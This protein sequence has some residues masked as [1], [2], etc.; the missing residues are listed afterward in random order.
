MEKKDIAVEQLK[1][2]ARH[3]NNRE[4]VCAITLASA[5]EEILG[6]IAKTRTGTNQLENELSYL[7]G[8][9]DYFSGTTP[10]SRELIAKINS[11]KNNLKHNDG[12]ENIWVEADFEFAAAELFIKAMRNYFDCYSE[13]LNDRT[14]RYLFEHLT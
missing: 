9:Y 3:Y 7:R 13:L 10:P 12:G 2:S 14:S 5:A 4:Y 11:V 8:I 6:Q 1:A